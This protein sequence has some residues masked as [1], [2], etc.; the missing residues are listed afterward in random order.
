MGKRIRLSNGRRLVDDVIRMANTMP[1]AGLSADLDVSEISQL[2]RLTRPKITWNVIMMKAYAQVCRENPELQRA[3][4]GFP[5]GHLHEHDEPVCMMTIAREHLG[6]ERLFFARFSRPDQFRL[7]LLQAQYDHFRK[8]PIE[9]IKQFRH[10]ILFAKAPGFVRRFAWWALFNVWPTKR[11]IHM[12]T[13]G[14]SIS[15]YNGAYGSLHLGPNTTTL[16]VDPI[17]RHG[18]SRTTLTFDHRVMDGTPATRILL[19]LQDK[20]STSI[21]DELKTLVKVGEDFPTGSA[22]TVVD[23]S[24]KKIDQAA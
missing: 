20:L 4:V 6:E 14:M 13:Y 7:P 5:W 23:P 3:Y 17:P 12:G 19:Q 22:S 24:P 8:S 11:A 9:E 15:G 2:R 16:G 21:R 18:V 1:I 10:Q